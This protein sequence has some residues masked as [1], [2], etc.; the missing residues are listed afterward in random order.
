MRDAVLLFGSGNRTEWSPIRSVVILV[1]RPPLFFRL[2]S[3]TFS[4]SGSVGRSEKK[5]KG[6]KTKEK[7]SGT[8]T[9][10]TPTKHV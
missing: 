7:K 3:N 5:K 6:P 9:Q 4:D 1:M 10:F 2:L 8:S